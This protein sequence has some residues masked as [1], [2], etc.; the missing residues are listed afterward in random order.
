LKRACENGHAAEAAEV[1]HA[2]KGSAM[3]VNAEVLTGVLV[4]LEDVCRAQKPG[5]LAAFIPRVEREYERLRNVTE[6]VFSV[7]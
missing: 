5:M 2:F 3:N 1:A 4:E 6:I 7:P